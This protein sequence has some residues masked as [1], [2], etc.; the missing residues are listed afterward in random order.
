[1]KNREFNHQTYRCPNHGLISGDEVGQEEIDYGELRHWCLKCYANTPYVGVRKTP[2][3][4][5]GPRMATWK[6]NDGTI[7]SEPW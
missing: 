6:N 5:P 4:K 7:H 2:K 3:S 1:M